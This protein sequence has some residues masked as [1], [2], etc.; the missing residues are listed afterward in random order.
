MNAFEDLLGAYG[1]WKE[2]SESEGEAIVRGDWSSVSA[3]QESKLHLRDAII[4]WTGRAREDWKA[5]GKDLAE[6]E[7]RVRSVVGE[8]IALETRNASALAEQRAVCQARRE[9]IEG[10]RRN[11]R[12]IRSSYANVPGASWQSYS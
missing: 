3:H 9:E 7:N 4:R 6:F 12:R 11:L 5:S 2:C 1:Q 8:L 10:S